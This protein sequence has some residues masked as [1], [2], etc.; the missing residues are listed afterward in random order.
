[1]VLSLSNPWSCCW[2][3]L[4][5]NQTVQIWSSFGPFC[6]LKNVSFSYG[7]FFTKELTSSIDVSLAPLLWLS[8]PIGVF[9]VSLIMKLWSIS[10]PL[11]YTLNRFGG[12]LPIC[13]Q[14]CFG[15]CLPGSVLKKFCCSKPAS[16]RNILLQNLIGAT[17]WSI[18]LERNDRTFHGHGG[19]GG[20]SQIQIW[21]YIL[22]LSAIWCSKSKLFCNYNIASISLNWDASL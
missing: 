5:L 6:F 18:W 4:I 19:G 2:P 20:K 15:S 7:P 1:M 12:T 3:L 16:K 17:L 21:E 11:V 9:S 22:N 10:L 8:I 13:G 14:I